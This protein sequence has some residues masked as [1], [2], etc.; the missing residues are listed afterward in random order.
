MPQIIFK[1]NIENSSNINRFNDNDISLIGTQ[2]II[3]SF[4]PNIDYIEYVLYDA[5]YNLLNL[6]YNYNFYKLPSQGSSLNNNSTYS[7]LEIDPLSDL[8]QYYEIG[9]FKTQYNFF[10]KWISNPQDLELFI[11]EISPDRT[12]LKISSVNINNLQEQLNKILTDKN[13]VSY[14]KPYLLNFGN[15]IVKTITNI[16]WDKGFI[17]VKL[18]ESLSNDIDINSTLCIVEEISTSTTFDLILTNELLADPLPTLRGPNFELDLDIRNTTPTKYESN[19]T[20]LSNYSGSS[21][22]SILNQINLAEIEINI[23]YSSSYEN[24]VRFSSAE[25]RL[26][27]FY[28]KIKQIEDYNS[29]ITQYSGS[30]QPNILIQVGQYSSSINDI[31]TKFDGYEN[32][33]YFNSGSGTWPKS[34][35]NPPYFLESTGSANVLT[36]FSSSIDASIYYDNNNPDKLSDAIPEYISIDEN[37]ESYVN[38]I[39]MIGHYFDNIWIYIKSIT[40]Y[41]KNYNNSNEG[42]SKDLVFFALQDL[43]VKLYNTKED[44]DLYNYIIGNN[45]NMSSQQLVAELYKRI[46]HNIPLLFKGKGSYKTIQ[47]LITTFGITGSIL[48]IKEYG[49]NSNTEASLLDYSSNKVRIID[50]SV[51]TASYGSI[52]H[53]KIKLA[54]DIYENY[55]NDDSRVDIAFSPQYPI[56]LIISA[57]I[58]SSNPNFS[59]DDYLGDPRYEMSSSYYA[60]DV[61]REIAISSSFTTKYDIRGFIEL[62]QYFDNTLFKMVKDYL[63]SKTN[64]S[65]G[66]VIK[67]QAL[68]RIKW[69]RN[70]PNIDNQTMYEATYSTA[71]IGSNYDGFYNFLT[72]SKEP[73]YNGEISGSDKNLYNDFFIPRNFNV[74]AL[75]S[76]LNLSLFQHSDYNVLLNNVSSSILS[77]VR[78]K[79]EIQPY[80]SQ[81]IL[82]PAEIQDSNYY[83]TGLNRSRY[84]GTKLTSAIYNDYT[85]GDIAFG[86]TSAIDIIKNNVSYFTNIK[87]S[88]LLLANVSQLKL[89]YLINEQNNVL[90]LNNQNNNVVDIQN[91]FKSGE[92]ITISYFDN[93]GSIK[94]S[95]VDI[96]I[97]KGG[98]GIDTVLYN[99]GS[100]GYQNF[101]LPNASDTIVSA[102]YDLVTSASISGMYLA[103][104]TIYQNGVLHSI[105]GSSITNDLLPYVVTSNLFVFVSHSVYPTTKYHKLVDGNSELLANIQ[106]SAS[107]PGP[108]SYAVASYN[109]VLG[110][111]PHPIFGLNID[112]S[113]FSLQGTH[114]SNYCKHG[115]AIYM[116]TG[117]A[118]GEEWLFPNGFGN[119]YQNSGSLPWK[120]SGS[121]RIVVFPK[122]ISDHYGTFRYNTNLNTNVFDINYTNFTID[123][124]DKFLVYPVDY[125]IGLSANVQ[126]H[127]RTYIFKEYNITD[128]YFT[129]FLGD[130]YLTIVVDQDLPNFTTGLPYNT[131]DKKYIPYYAVQK[132]VADETSILLKSTNFAD[133]ENQG[134]VYPQYV[135]KTL[136]TKSGDIIKNLKSQNLI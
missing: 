91:I 40:D 79:I 69:K 82:V 115:G 127:N 56:D 75:S 26:D 20:L 31:V 119:V 78:R 114:N 46:Y 92:N 42:I 113:S 85:A 21:I 111:S 96:E 65:E 71:S 7:I 47:E 34:N 132:I 101:E 52:L 4:D 43:G 6:D 39:N 130:D 77:N 87:Q 100:S 19:N 18:Y 48:N 13:S 125:A 15:N 60:L 83:D 57:S 22:E 97:Y 14:L 8:Q 63:P 49:G 41:Y 45:G 98:Y 74:W 29:F 126:Y 90:D 136:K 131:D 37:N 112:S 99:L 9:E 66:I 128:T 123:K 88:S 80:S 44:D 67:Q 54:D 106:I 133:S 61:T 93:S 107:S 73:Y 24:F 110:G 10:K 116:S 32:Y 23:N 58:T 11:K 3:N 104:Y 16:A 5:A 103:S 95:N 25:K 124:G 118:T 81:S 2:N 33:L 134:I 135:N 38:F 86:K 27:N 105:T 36:W 50:N 76:S 51:Y 120:A 1:G 102:S 17:V 129:S 28:D 35:I 122:Q 30:N 109:F 121:N 89:K 84:I 64:L 53:P 108:S 70:L 12:E 72:G 62:S 59:I 55:K 68:E 94:P 117:Y